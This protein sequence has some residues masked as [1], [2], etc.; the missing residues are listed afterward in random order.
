[1]RIRK[2]T[3]DD[4]MKIISMLADDELGKQRENFT[5]PL[6]EEYY[7]AYENIEADKNQELI[8]LENDEREIIGTLHLTLYNILPIVEGSGH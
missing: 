7:A 3:R 5:D 4:V 8:V 2:A 1:M 6:P